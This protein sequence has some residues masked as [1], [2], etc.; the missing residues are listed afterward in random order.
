VADWHTR[1]WRIGYKPQSTIF[2]NIY[3]QKAPS[4]TFDGRAW[5]YII[6]GE[7]VYNA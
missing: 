3:C 7:L 2:H 4:V 1:Q 5:C 6:S